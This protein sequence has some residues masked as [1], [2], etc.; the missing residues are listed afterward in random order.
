[1]WLFIFVGQLGIFILNL[2]Y[3]LAGVTNNDTCKFPIKLNSLKQYFALINQKNVLLDDAAVCVIRIHT[4]S[5]HT[6]SLL[7]IPELFH[8][9]YISNK[10]LTHADVDYFDFEQS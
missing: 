8:M 2:S 10:I 6:F 5:V 1:M 4:L 3:E 7:W 9:H